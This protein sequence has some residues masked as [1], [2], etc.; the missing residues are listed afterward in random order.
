M[1][2]VLGICLNSILPVLMNV[3]VVGDLTNQHDQSLISN[4]EYASTRKLVRRA[5]NLQV[6]S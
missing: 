1:V 5:W 3:A 2:S 6:G 4:H